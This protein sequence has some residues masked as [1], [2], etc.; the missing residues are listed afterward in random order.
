MALLHLPYIL[1]SKDML[2]LMLEYIYKNMGPNRQQ[3]LVDLICI[4]FPLSA[5]SENASAQLSLSA[6]CHFFFLPWKHLY[7]LNH[8]KELYFHLTYFFWL[9]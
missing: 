9:C 2:S 1:Y 6:T 4:F 7:N 3:R 5:V 8:K